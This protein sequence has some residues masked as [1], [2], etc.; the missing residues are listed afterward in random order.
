MAFENYPEAENPQQKKVETTT[1]TNSRNNMRSILTG[2]L[3]VA[4][5]GTWGYIIYDKNK[6]RETLDQKETVIA[7]TSTQRDELQKELEDAAMKYDM[8]KTSNSKKDSA[9][10]AKDRDI[11]DKK[12]RIQQ[13]LNKQNATQSEL[14]EAKRLI[15]SLNGDLENYRTQ[16]EVL[17][18]QKIQL[19]Q[20]KAV[21]TQQRD[22]VLKDF[23]SAT[24]VIK[25]K[26]DLINVGSTLHA[27]NFSIVG[28]DEKSS[29]KEKLTSTAKRVD[30]LRISFDLDENMLAQTGP[31]EIFIC[32]TA[33][34][35]TPVSVE[36]LGSGTFSTRDGQQKTFTQKLDV[37]YTQAKKQTVSFDW[38][39]N[40]NYNT[41]NYKIE[42]YN[43]GFKVGEASKP[44]K[45]GGLF[46]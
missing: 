35:G 10:T 41:G 24:V 30:K 11:E 9:I 4:L 46:S 34:D 31:K 29:G 14:S 18:G 23:D 22:K 6:T 44:L 42:V 13:L 36:A 21:V 3:V 5:L 17:Q 1:T 12:V 7:S 38:K 37:N 32:I 20:E 28:I 26:E 25:E 27:S 19:T 8:L 2:I 15:A 40:S 45:K 39:Q 33:P 43:N 16:I